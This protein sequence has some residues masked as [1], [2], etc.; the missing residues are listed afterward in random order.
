MSGEALSRGT[1]RRLAPEVVQTSNMDCG[2]AAL[3]CLLEG[4]GVSTHYGHLRD[5]CQ[6]DVDGTSINTLE[7]I[8]RELG[9]DVVQMV[10]PVDHLPLAHPGY[11]PAIAVTRLPNGNTH[12]VV[13]W[14]NLTWRNRARVVQVMDPASGRRWPSVRTFLK[15]LYIHTMRVAPADWRAWAGGEDFTRPLRERTLA[16]QVPDAVATDLVEQA[17][18]PGDWLALAFFD[19]AV[20]M[21][22]SLVDSGAIRRGREATSLL[23]RLWQ[24]FAEDNSQAPRLVPEEYWCVRPHTPPNKEAEEAADAFDTAPEQ[25]AFRGAVVLQARGLR[26]EDPGQPRARAFARVLDAPP[27]QPLRRLWGY[28]RDDSLATTAI[29]ALA[30]IASVIG[31]MG[32][33]LLFRGLIDIHSALAPGSQRLATIALVLGFMATLLLLQYPAARLQM[34]IGRRLEVRFRAQLLRHL[35]DIPGHFFHSRPTSDTGERGHKVS[36]LREIPVLASSMVFKATALLATCAGIIWLAPGAATLVLLMAAVQVVIPLLFQ[37]VLGDHNMRVQTHAGALA[38]F[39]MDALLGVIPIRTHGA[40]DAIRREHEHLL[41]E[42]TRAGYTFLRYQLGSQAIQALLNTLLAALLVA[43]CINTAGATPALLLVIYWVLALPPLGEEIASLLR[44][45]P[46][47]RNTLLRALEPLEAGDESAPQASEQ[48]APLPDLTTA[49]TIQFQQVS[50]IAGGRTIL[51]DI[52]LEIRPGEHIAIVGESGAGK[53]SLAGLLLGWLRPSGGQ[54]MVDGAPLHGELLARLRQRSVWVDPA[55]HLWNRSLLENLRYGRSGSDA[56]APLYPVLDQADLLQLVAALPDGLQ[57][58]LGEGGALVSGGEGQRVRLGRA[59]GQ[60]D[61]ACA[62]LDEPFRGL[63][64]HQ[65]Q[66]LLGRVRRI[67]GDATLLCI[68]H[69]VAETQQFSRVLVIADGRIAEDGAPAELAARKDSRYSALLAAEQAVWQECWDNS[70]WRHL[71][72][73]RGHL[74]EAAPV[75]DATTPREAANAQ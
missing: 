15:E 19:G 67:W 60:A 68:T 14:R 3:K 9:L 31:I 74:Q 22:A 56:D 1:P 45:Y 44:E 17:L 57:T 8:A 13:A 71:R 64:R 58:H 11:L 61:P 2:P 5:A 41:V 7:Q 54:L 27:P 59:L 35:P 62:I 46:R 26:E 30:L 38:R 50:A 10:V 23:Q 65:R 51:Q 48:N 66:R 16:L 25:V 42:W 28:L 69:D 72:M 37:P 24:Q 29:L 34:D 70:A 55:V 32:E 12:F 73:E 39:Y 43:H 6:T 21:L 75:S 63:D 33:A 18:Q 47:L 36:A 52:D 4:F 20:R 53:S 40:G 49:P